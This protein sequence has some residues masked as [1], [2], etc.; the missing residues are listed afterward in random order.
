MIY[1][2]QQAIGPMGKDRQMTVSKL[3]NR[4]W[5]V[6][7]II[8]NYLVTRTYFYF[9]KREAIAKFRAEFFL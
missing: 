1:N 6:S 9:T 7:D 5:Q 8:D 3:H 4:A 2:L